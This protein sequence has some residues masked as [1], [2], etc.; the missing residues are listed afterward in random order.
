MINNQIVN[1][2]AASG[3]AH[4]QFSFKFE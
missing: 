1:G 3:F 2:G 4:M